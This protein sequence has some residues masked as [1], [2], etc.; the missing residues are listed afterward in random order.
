MTKTTLRLSLLAGFIAIAATSVAVAA[1]RLKTP[2]SS[3][4]RGAEDA[5]VTIVEYLDYE[6]GFCKK[7]E[8]TMQA[9]LE[10]YPGKVRIEL[11]H[12][13]LP[14]HPNA[15][16]AASA[17]VAAG[18]QGKL[19]EMHDRLINTRKIDRAVLDQHAAALGLNLGR[20]ASD[21]ESARAKVA[22]DLERGK[23][24]GVRG[25]PA[26]FIN[27]KHV[28]GAQPIEAFT[29][30]IDAELGGSPVDGPSVEEQ[31]EC[32]PK[33]EEEPGCAH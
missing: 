26:F 32:G 12:N 24:A 4:Y 2:A 10:R 8:K 22:A 7:S 23:A 33:V 16:L 1:V 15:E 29:R 6:C 30:V 25:T 5:P 27:G 17:V 31:I 9:L 3:K 19:W 21:L 20:F 28:V 13:P 11:A 14:M 18:E